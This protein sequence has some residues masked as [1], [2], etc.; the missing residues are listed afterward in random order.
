MSDLELVSARG[1]IARKKPEKTGQLTCISYAD[2]RA[3]RFC[4]RRRP[5]GWCRNCSVFLHRQSANPPIDRRRSGTDRLESDVLL[6]T[7]AQPGFGVNRRARGRLWKGLGAPAP[8]GRGRRGR[9]RTLV[10]ERR[11]RRDRAEC[12]WRRTPL[13]MAR[14][15]PS[16]G[17]SRSLMSVRRATCGLSEPSVAAPRSQPSQ[18]GK[19]SGRNSSPGTCRVSS[20]V[21]WTSTGPPKAWS[22][23]AGEHQL[24][25]DVLRGRLL[26]RNARR[27]SGIR[28]VTT[29]S[30]VSNRHV[31]SLRV[32]GSVTWLRLDGSRTA[33]VVLAEVLEHLDIAATTDGSHAVNG[34]PDL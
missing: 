26:A 20:Q 1:A 9:C 34:L 30:A 29:V 11:H 7:R 6:S 15:R 21:R 17:P 3:N 12:A 4:G 14:S 2:A 19:V 31:E 27:A 10:V 16:A 24:P 23:Y 13:S 32:V 8:T 5:D 18:G 28:D 33:S 22:L 25:I